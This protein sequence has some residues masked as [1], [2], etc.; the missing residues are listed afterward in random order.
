[1]E[2]IS[3]NLLTFLLNSLWQIPLVAC[4]AWL[5]CRFMSNGP[6]RHRH[7]V[8]V[9]ALVTAFLLPLASTSIWRTAP[10][11][12]A[13]SI[14]PEQAM[15]ALATASPASLPR[16][17]N[18][19]PT[20]GGRTVTFAATTA[21][22]FV[23]IYAVLLLLRLVALTVGLVRTVRIH[24][25]SYTAEPSASLSR[26]WH[27]CLHALG[28]GRA[29]LLFSSHLSGPVA[30]AKTIFLPESLATEQS[31]DVL[32]TAVGHE[33]AHVVR[34]DFACNLFYEALH[35]LVSYHPAAWLI[36]REI[37]RTRE[38]ACDEMVAEHLLDADVYARS[39]VSIAA[40]MMALPQP[41]YTL[42]VFDGN[43]LEERIRSLMERRGVNFKR[44][45][46]AL[47]TGL[48]ALLVCG[49][50]ASMIAITARAQSGA[51]AAISEGN[52]A[53]ARRDFAGAIAKFDSAVQLDP[54]S[55]KAKLGLALAILSNS[56]P[57]DWAN[58]NDAAGLRARQLF[59]NVLAVEPRNI[60]AIDGMA[61][62][63][64]YAK[65]F[66][67]AKQWARKGIEVDPTSSGAYYT[68]GFI[69]WAVTYPDYVKARSAAGMQLADPGIIPDAAQRLAVRLQHQADLD[70]G[71]Q[72]L[73]VALQIKPDYDDAMA[74]IN[75][76]YRIKAALADNREQYDALT[77][78]ADGWVGKALE[79]KRQKMARAAV[80]GE[81]NG[82]VTWQ[83]APP[84]PP[85]PP[86]PAKS[87]QAM[88]PQSVAIS[89]DVQH[90]MLVE[91]QPPAY[92]SLAQRAGV[93][94]T[95]QVS[96]LI[97]KDGSVVKADFVSGPPL[98]AEAALAAARQAKFRPTLV[99]GQPVEVVTTMATTFQPAK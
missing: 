11:P 77:A 35:L 36:R 78:Q 59:Q 13:I 34:R 50:A 53:M 86:P 66:A 12:A 49:V 56:Q 64:L 76:L 48:S 58:P 41:D 6:A 97:G 28:L 62:I 52:A 69:D 5:V 98:L 15:K 65:Q 2:T 10:Q 60:Q 3:R 44:A 25:H 46:L 43:I 81:S 9:A 22:V 8:W 21:L 37:E 84:P 23:G 85:P 72:S 89:W 83:V 57:A 39:I 45:R 94:G 47:I 14:S 96:L 87:G 74:Y 90:S 71:M 33:M 61:N 68:I 92:P 79:T 82:S 40:G 1:M 42:G 95:V 51:D 80:T 26:V 70:E 55:T 91:Y 4:V 30:S 24:Q 19:A 54:A 17:A 93:T 29:D 20:Q 32:T 18:P 63:T 73:Q 67:E 88:P 31:E 16:P 75:L 99:N 7:A 27:R 38:M